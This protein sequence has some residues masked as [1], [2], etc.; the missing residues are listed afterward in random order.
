MPESMPEIKFDEH[1]AEL[2]FRY[3]YPCTIF[4]SRYGGSYEPGRWV[5]IP[6]DHIPVDA[7][8]DDVT[9]ASWFADYGWMCGGGETPGDALVDLNS[10]L[11]PRY[12][13]VSS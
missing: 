4:R 1:D 13:L 6:L 2:F 3:G 12:P 9:C 8:D 7:T 10:K 5:A 11:R